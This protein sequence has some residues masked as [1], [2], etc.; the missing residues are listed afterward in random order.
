MA[1]TVISAFNEFLKEKVNLDDTK[2]CTA[3][4]SRDWL[5]DNIHEF[6]NIDDFPVLY[7]DRDVF[8]GSFARKTKIREL[9]DI[10]IMIGLSAQGAKY[11]ETTTYDNIEV[12]VTA[13][14]KGLKN[15]CDDGTLNLNSRKVINKFIS[16]LKNISQY[17]NADISRNLE[18]AT[19]KLKSYT[20]NFDIVPCFYTNPDING[21]E[22]YIIPNGNGKWKKTDPRMDGARVS[23]I[24]QKLGGHVLNVIRIMKYWNC[25]PTMPTIGSYCLETMILNYYDR[26]NDCSGYVD[27]EIPN[28]LNYL[29][30]AVCCSVFDSK[31]IQGE[32]NMLSYE[33]KV[34]ISERASSDYQKAINARTLEDAHDYKGSINKWREIFGSEFPD[35]SN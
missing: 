18:A 9:D 6:E 10:D 11:Y 26:T 13:D 5:K 16:N 19:L 25:R 1:N 31:N 30:T 24:N 34:K 29:S 2:N 22:Y 20:W 14:S 35:W 23:S 4:S 12:T 28:L 27:I 21:R 7:S 33:N 32:L 17:E 15:L 3:R 8:F